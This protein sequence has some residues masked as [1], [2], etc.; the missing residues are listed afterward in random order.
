[1]MSKSFAMNFEIAKLD[2]KVNDL[3]TLR[4]ILMTMKS[5][6][7]VNQQLFVSVDTDFKNENQVNFLYSKSTTGSKKFHC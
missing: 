6:E 7:D 4:S 1:M 5:K 3:P 2:T